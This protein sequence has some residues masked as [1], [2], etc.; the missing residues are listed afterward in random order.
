MSIRWR[1]DRPIVEV[2]DPAIGKK[3]HIK[4]ADFGM[5]LRGL[6]GRALQRAARELEDAALDHYERGGPAADETCDS[7]AARWATDYDGQGATPRGESTRIVNAERVSKFGED[8]KGRPLRS[9]T[10]D[11]ARRWAQAHGY[12][13]AAVRAMFTD[14]HRDGLVDANVFA[15]LGLKQGRG[16]K[17]ILVL[18]RDEVHELA[19]TALRVWGDSEV[20]H[21]TRALILWAA[22]TCM[23]PGEIFAARFSQLHGD[24]YDVDRQWN[25]KTRKETDPK[26]GSAG[27]IFVPQEARDAVLD[28][29]RRLGDDLM[30]RTARGHQLR[31]GSW[32][33]L[34]NPVRAAFVAGLPLGHHLHRRVTGD[35]LDTY[36]L[37]H[38]GAS[39][40]LNVL[41]LEPWVIAEQLR[42]TDGGTL[43]LS[44]YGHPDRSVA[45]DRIRGAFQ[46]SGENVPSI[47]GRSGDSRGIRRADR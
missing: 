1:N 31:Q 42:H 19:D 2:Y 23:R 28:K 41:G 47:E 3:R 10:R 13:L 16:R 29:P 12:R 6:S 44:R 35:L 33:Y 11:E 15:G 43:V 9:I 39:Y 46:G 26:W 37:R 7:F 30:F 40:M 27:L 34:W 22:Y 14:A 45:L 17:D 18:S 36:E 25:S 32:H 38:F 5:N 20:G 24:T 21:D 4:P 8:F